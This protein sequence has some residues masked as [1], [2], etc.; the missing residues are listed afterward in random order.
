LQNWYNGGME[1]NNPSSEVN[2]VCRKCGLSLGIDQ[3][4]IRNDTGKC[5]GSC[6]NC[7][8]VESKI[9]R[10]DNK[11]YITISKREWQKSN[12]EKRALIQKR[13]Y[14]KNKENIKT[15]QRYYKREKQSLNARLISNY[16][17]RLWKAIVRGDRSK[18]TMEL[19][20]CSIE[21]LKSKLEKRFE[22]GMNWH[23]YGEWH[24]DYIRPCASFDL[25]KQEDQIRCFNYKNLQP[26]WA[27]D[28]K[29]KK[30]KWNI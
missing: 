1:N 10:H 28:N 25:S 11:E 9:Y 23:N 7:W 26:L 14:A 21:F 16:R 24:I 6:K 8:S 27:E 17:G 15:Y 12:P 13:Y 5:R 29:S 18:H 19:L 2:I 3:F 4:Y 30:D 20:G 22:D